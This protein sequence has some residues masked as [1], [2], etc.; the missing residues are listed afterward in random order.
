MLWHRTTRQVH[1][2]SIKRGQA[3]AAHPNFQDISILF[4]NREHKHL[5]LCAHLMMLMAQLLM[6][7]KMLFDGF[8]LMIHAEFTFLCTTHCRCRVCRC[9]APFCTPAA[10]AVA[11]LLWK[12]KNRVWCALACVE[13]L[14]D[15]AKLFNMHCICCSWLQSPVR[16]CIFNL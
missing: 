7:H 1:A 10:A 9:V 16:K 15:Y 12:S 3:G 4:R 5:R 8:C 14:A 6:I 2:M 13:C 11:I